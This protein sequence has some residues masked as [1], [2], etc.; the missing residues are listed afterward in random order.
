MS[1]P[2]PPT[3]GPSDPPGPGAD[4]DATAGGESA[5][6][7]PPTGGSGA[8]RPGLLP[9]LVMVAGG[10][11]VAVASWPAFGLISSPGADESWELPAF[12]ESAVEEIGDVD[13]GASWLLSITPGEILIGVGIVLMLLGLAVVL[14]RPR[15][16]RVAAAVAAVVV[17]VACAIFL[18]ADL[19]YHQDHLNEV[20]QV[21]ND[22][23]AGTQL[24]DLAAFPTD[25]EVSPARGM[26]AGLFGMALVVVGAAWTLIDVARHRPSPALDD[27]SSS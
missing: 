1:E 2:A 4:V 15:A 13:V 6:P 10:L 12:S 26:W 17:A 22:R 5:A 19:A 9:G 14:A 11:V 18:F 24:E 8:R 20:G 16:G 3:A 21:F 23:L 25:L 27:P 7:A